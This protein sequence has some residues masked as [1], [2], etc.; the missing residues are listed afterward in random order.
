[1][2]LHQADLIAGQ[3]LECADALVTAVSLLAI[4][5]AATY[6]AMRALFAGDSAAAESCRRWAVTATTA[7][8]GWCVLAPDLGVEPRA[9]VML[10]VAAA[11]CW[12]VPLAWPARHIPRAAARRRSS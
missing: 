3:T 10:A 9:P 5:G 1:M 2:S 7:L 8:I 4:A 11:C 6:S 12:L